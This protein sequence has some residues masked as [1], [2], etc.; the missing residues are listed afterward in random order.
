MSR[1][2][3]GLTAISLL[4]IA[5]SLPLCATAPA[6]IDLDIKAPAAAESGRS[7]TFATTAGAMTLYLEI[8]DADTN[9]ILGRAVDR[10]RA[11]D[12]GRMTWQNSATNRTEARRLVT[13]WADTLRN[14]LDAVRA[15]RPPGAARRRRS[16][17][18]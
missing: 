16:E 7:R 18:P 13:D 17:V 2:S 10:K 5:L 11:R 4:S 14:G 12:Y 15:S 8:Y 6:I 3:A 1:R 9:E